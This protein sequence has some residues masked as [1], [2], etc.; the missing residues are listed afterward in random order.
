MLLAVCEGLEDLKSESLIVSD[1][2]QLIMEGG[3]GNPKIIRKV[4]ISPLKLDRAV[5]LSYVGS[6]GL[7]NRHGYGCH[8]EYNS[9]DDDLDDDVSG[10]NVSGNWLCSAF[11]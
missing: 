9:K 7:L 6:Y 10:R 11:G 4:A 1:A 2:G 3:D 5:L 8:D